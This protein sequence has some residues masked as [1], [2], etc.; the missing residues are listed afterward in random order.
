MSGE[1]LMHLDLE[2]GAYN[3]GW[4]HALLS[5]AVSRAHR[6]E[7]PLTLV[8]VDLDDTAVLLDEEGAGA[9]QL[10]LDHVA[11]AISRAVDGLG[12]IGRVDDDA[13]AVLILGAG[14]PHSTR[15]AHAIRREVA[16]TAVQLPGGPRRVTASVGVALL[17]PHE[18]WGNLAEAAE[19]ACIRAKQ[20]GRNRVAPR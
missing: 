2:T 13:L 6:E 11:Q 5:E 3:R 19:A 10:A 12:P 17:R 4:F 15:L 18:P 8:W 14:L 20:G 9:V 16:A 1:R 7:A